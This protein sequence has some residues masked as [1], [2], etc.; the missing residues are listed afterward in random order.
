MEFDVC[1]G[2]YPKFL[3]K[4]VTCS[5]KNSANMTLKAAVGFGEREKKGE[6]VSKTVL[7]V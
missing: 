6:R 7:A 5:I 2:N 1:D 3:S 4:G